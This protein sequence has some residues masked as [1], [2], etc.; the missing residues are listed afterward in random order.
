MDSSESNRFSG[1]FT[2]SF[3][4]RLRQRRQSLEL[5]YQDTAR[6]LGVHWTTMRGWECGKMRSC[7]PI[8]VSKVRRFMEGEYDAVIGPLLT[9]FKTNGN[10]A[11]IP[12]ELVECV[13]DVAAAASRCGDLELVE[14]HKALDSL[15]LETVNGLLTNL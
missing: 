3:A 6:F 7:N 4:R 12:D 8:H 10:L 14:L 15:L 5:S 13:L 9:V 11:A 2:P 1:T